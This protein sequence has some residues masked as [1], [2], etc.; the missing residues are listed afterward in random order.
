MLQQAAEAPA[1]RLPATPGWARSSRF[2]QLAG[3]NLN[4]A[5]DVLAR[6]AR[7]PTVKR[8]ELAGKTTPADAY[9]VAIAVTVSLMFVALLLAA[10]ML[11]LERE[12]NT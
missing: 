12:E 10:G 3:D 11:A 7:R 2:A 5:T 6:S 4:L 9:A 1:A 8:T